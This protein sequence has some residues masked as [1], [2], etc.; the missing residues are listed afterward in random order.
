MNDDRFS[1]SMHKDKPRTCGVNSASDYDGLRIRD[2]VP[3][4]A[5]PASLL[6]A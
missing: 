5:A 2:L 3:Y 6:S 1:Y 4:P